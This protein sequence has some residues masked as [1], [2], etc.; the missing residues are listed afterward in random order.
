MMSD[1]DQAEMVSEAAIRLRELLDDRDPRIQVRAAH[2]ILE[3]AGFK[4]AIEEISSKEFVC[5]SCDEHFYCSS[6]EARFCPKCGSVL[7]DD[8]DLPF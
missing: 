2:I 6:D 5:K 1:K 4:P 8:D 3:L 7:I